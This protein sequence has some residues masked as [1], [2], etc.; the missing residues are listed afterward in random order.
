M[1]CYSLTR[2]KS[3]CGRSAHCFTP[4]SACNVSTPAAAGSAPQSHSLLLRRSTVARQPA[5]RIRVLSSAVPVSPP[6][7]HENPPAAVS[8]AWVASYRAWVDLAMNQPVE[9]HGTDAKGV[10]WNSSVHVLG[11][12]HHSA[13]N[14]RAVHEVAAAVGPDAVAFENDGSDKTWRNR[15]TK[16][17]QSAPMMKLV[18]RLMH[19][20]LTSYQQAHGQLTAKERVEWVACLDLAGVGL[21]PFSSDHLLL[22]MPAYSDPIAAAFIA[23]KLGASFI[24]IECPDSRSMS[25]EAQLKLQEEEEAEGE[26]EEQEESA[27]MRLT[28]QALGESLAASFRLWEESDLGSELLRSAAFSA[29]LDAV[30]PERKP[31][32]LASSPKKMQE[33]SVQRERGMCHTIVD[34]CSGKLAGKPRKRVLV[35]VG[36]SHVAPLIEL[37]KAV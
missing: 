12:C 14:A 32:T 2:T 35:I 36:R 29:M 15:M 3:A 11:V 23:R 21:G 8:E 24:F 17:A 27:Y 10:A 13:A 25:A 16:V 31:S 22:G 26:R 7:P 5:R 20:P 18:N 4:P 19:T 1:S 37:L 28:E 34:L 33:A 30:M 6:G 9:L